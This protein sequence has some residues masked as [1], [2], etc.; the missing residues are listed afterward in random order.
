MLTIIMKARRCAGLDH[1]LSLVN[2][3]G[4]WEKQT[5]ITP[6]TSQQSPLPL[7]LTYLPGNVGGRDVCI[8]RCRYY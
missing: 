1:V 6:E 7:T 3:V 5:G 2:D 4:G 8:T